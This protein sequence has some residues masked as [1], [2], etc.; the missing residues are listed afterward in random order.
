MRRHKLLVIGILLTLSVSA[1]A[2]L[3]SSPSRPGSIYAGVSLGASNFNMPNF[4]YGSQNGSSV[5]F[6]TK[7][8]T[9]QGELIFGIVFNKAAGGSNPLDVGHSV[10][11]GKD[12]K[13]KS[14][15]NPPIQSNEGESKVR[16]MRLE[17][18]VR[19]AAGANTTSKVLSNISLGYIN[20]QTAFTAF[21]SE[22]NN[23]LKTELMYTDISI[24]M[25]ADIVPDS[26]SFGSV[27]IAFTPYVGP[28]VL[29]IN[30]KF[31]LISNPTNNF[32]G[33]S[34]TIDEELDSKLYGI[35]FGGN[36]NFQL[37]EMF[38]MFAGANFTFLNGNTTLDGKQVVSN[39]F[40][41]ASAGTYIVNQQSSQTITKI[42]G[43]LGGT[44]YMSHG[45]LTLYTDI[46]SFNNMP[47][48]NNPSTTQ[49]SATVGY[50]KATVS[51][52]GVTYVYPF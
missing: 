39:N 38:N 29:L 51:S 48:V 46:D 5:D 25:K 18:S 8:T 24:L 19:Y 32:A 40:G 34:N 15:K 1:L 9:A 52:V 41:T 47:F 13:K 21:G 7:Q 16:N 36:V 6:E 12:T 49:G 14:K 35:K 11:T 28:T 26:L 10:E 27:R 44:V 2:T 22:T 33:S 31:N 20:G 17:T 37:N 45:S 23:Q 50:K 30:Q 42:G 4:V 3:S 43:V